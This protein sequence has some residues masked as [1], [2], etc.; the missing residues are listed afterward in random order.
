M[1]GLE[2]NWRMRC[3]PLNCF[4]AFLYAG[5]RTASSLHIG[6]GKQGVAP[7]SF[8]AFQISNLQ[9]QTISGVLTRG[10]VIECSGSVGEGRIFSHVDSRR[11]FMAATKI[12]SRRGIKAE[13]KRARKVVKVCTIN[14][15][16]EELFRF[17]RN[18][19]NLPRF[20]K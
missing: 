9:F 13:A 4:M 18:L 15:S 17:W 3:G 5:R 11:R 16:A 2:S 10:A 8:R 19:E 12:Q 20:A 7:Q 14:R 6:A 1:P